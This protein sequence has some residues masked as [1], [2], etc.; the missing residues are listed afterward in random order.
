MKTI[1]SNFDKENENFGGEFSIL[2]SDRF[3]KNNLFSNQTKSNIYTGFLYFL[4][5]VSVTC[6][7]ISL[8][9]FLICP[10]NY[11]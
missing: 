5:I 8:N 11:L 10:S 6:W 9:I 2:N 1:D 3:E 4:S 7:I